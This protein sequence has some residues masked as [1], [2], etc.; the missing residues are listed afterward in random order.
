MEQVELKEVMRQELDS[1]IL[2]NAT[3]LRDSLKTD[4][5]AHFSTKGFEDIFRMNSEKMEDGLRYCYDNYGTGN[6]IIICRSN[7][8]AVKYNLFIRRQIHFSEN[9]LDV[10]DI[11]M[12]VRNNYFYSPEGTPSGFIANGDFLEITKIYGFEEMH[13]HRF[14]N[15]ELRFYGLDNVEG[16]DAK[17]LLDTLFSDTPSLSQEKNREL[18][19]KVSRDYNDLGSA[20]KMREAV[21]NDEYLNALQI[22]FAYALT[23]HKS[24]GGQW[25]AVFVD[26]G[27]I[28]DDQIDDDFT[29]W[30]YTAVT[31]ATS[32]LFL[33]NFRSEQFQN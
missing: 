6:T 20:K 5:R 16:F 12:V 11:L 18:Y 24:Q 26:Q 4:K 23:C 31:R 17:V 1:G 15:L 30:L 22:K 8:N 21:R 3:Y 10:G 29:R 33:L 9:E 14:A 13:G 2:F 28:K 19:L 25:D 7:R 32:V 27:Y